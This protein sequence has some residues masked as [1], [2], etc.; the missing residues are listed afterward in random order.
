ML[1]HIQ[2]QGDE[3]HPIRPFHREFL[4]DEAAIS[5]PAHMS[6]IS[7]INLIGQDSARMIGVVNH[8]YSGPITQYYN[9][10]VPGNFSVLEWLW[11]QCPD[12]HSPA[13]APYAK[14]DTI[15]GSAIEARR[16]QSEPWLI[17]R[18]IFKEWFTGTGGPL[19]I[20][21]KGNVALSTSI[22]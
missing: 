19:W 18:G 20:W 1:P 22:P 11:P 17:E 13:T 12:P 15:H 21:G 2:E 6:D 3:Q 10:Q 16:G 14:Q 4:G 7:T 9:N 8:N 5:Q